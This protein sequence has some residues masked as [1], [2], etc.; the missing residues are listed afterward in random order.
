MKSAPSQQEGAAILSARR[1]EFTEEIISAY[2]SCTWSEL[3]LRRHGWSPQ[4]LQKAAQKACSDYV[5]ANVPH[6]PNHRRDELVD[7]VVEKSLVAIMSFRPDHATTS[8]GRDGGKHFDSWLYD[9]MMKRCI[10]WYRSK[11][12]GNGDRRYGNDNRV[13]YEEDI[14]VD[15]WGAV[16]AGLF[17]AIEQHLTARS[18]KHWMQARDHSESDKDIAEWVVYV[19]NKEAAR[20]IERPKTERPGIV[21][22][23]ADRESY[24]PGLAA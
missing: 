6:L 12:E 4:R 17:Q 10:D 8:Y 2:R 18:L 20:I 21:R 19:V 16:V 3:A 24:W 1:D 23:P 15:P 11:S 5:R 13:Q 14:D 22:E 7:F 9:V